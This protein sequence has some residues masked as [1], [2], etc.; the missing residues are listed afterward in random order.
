VLGDL[1]IGCVLCTQHQIDILKENNI[2]D[3]K[4]LS[5]EKRQNFYPIIKKNCIDFKVG[6]IPVEIIDKNLTKYPKKSL[7][8]LEMELM[9]D[10]IILMDPD[11]IYIDAIGSNSQKFTKQMEEMLKE[12]IDFSAKIIARHKADSIFTVVGAASILAKVDRDRSI[13]NYKNYYSEFGDIGS[14]Y[15][16]DKKTINFL[17]SYVKKNRKLPPIARKSWK[18]SDNILND[19]LR[20]KKITDF[21]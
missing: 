9:R 14:G 2:D 20:Q 12:K 15:T 5:K 18:T 19:I 4:K 6:S 21:I 13:E 17:R 16:S 1:F 11:E 3:S 8:V 10:L 7:N